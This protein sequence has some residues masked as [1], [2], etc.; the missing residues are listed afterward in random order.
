MLRQG[1][2]ADNIIGSTIG[3]KTMYGS[4]TACRYVSV[5]ACTKD[6]RHLADHHHAHLYNA[7]TPPT[8]WQGR[9]GRRAGGLQGHADARRLMQLPNVPTFHVLQLITIAIDQS[10]KEEKELANGDQKID[11]YKKII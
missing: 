1:H 2:L 3:T 4:D 7:C 11:D 8:D 10:Q 9:I 6:V 5:Q